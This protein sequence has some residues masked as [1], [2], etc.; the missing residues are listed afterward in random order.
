MQLFGFHAK[1][2]ALIWIS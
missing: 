1:I 2:Q